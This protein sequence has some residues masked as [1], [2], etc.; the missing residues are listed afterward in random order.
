[1]RV[2]RR[3]VDDEHGAVAVLVALCSVLLFGFVALVIDAG[4]IW[5]TRRDLVTATDAAALAAAS[6]YA[7]RGNGCSSTAASM[8]TKNVLGASVESCVSRTGGT[9]DSGLVTVR[10]GKTVQFTFASVFGL[11][12]ERVRST[13]T[14]EWGQPSAALGLRPLAL[15][16]AASPQFLTWLNLPA[17]PTG[18]SQTLRIT[19]GKSQPFGCGW[20]PGN[21]GELDFNGGPN[22]N[23]ETRNWMRDGYPGVVTIGA[24]VDGNTGAFSNSI[25]SELAALVSSGSPFAIAVFDWVTGFGSNSQF[26]L[27]AFV[28]ARLVGYRT[29]GPQASRYLDLVFSLGV[30]EGICCQNGVDTGARALRICDIDTLTPNTRDARAC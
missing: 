13:T 15:C 11:D 14:A 19:Y 10:G 20:A 18:P 7:T 16:I 24:S 2:T 1:M 8:M 25:S 22:S 23:S 5:Q 30:L 27:V 17:G 26:H 3:L 12:E 9:P 28:N 21:W 6:D 29:T 4:A